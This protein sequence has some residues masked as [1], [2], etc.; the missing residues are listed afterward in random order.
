MTLGSL[1]IHPISESLAFFQSTKEVL[2]NRLGALHFFLLSTTWRIL[3][4]R[5]NALMPLLPYAL[6]PTT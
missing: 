2:V 3:W 4:L 5:R 1:S 6:S